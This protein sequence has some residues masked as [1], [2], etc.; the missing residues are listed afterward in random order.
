M[1]L[2]LGSEEGALG[3][4]RVTTEG[5]ESQLPPRFG[6]FWNLAKGKYHTSYSVRPAGLQRR[7]RT[8]A[9][10]VCILLRSAQFLNTC[11]KSLHHL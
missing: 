6:T 2:A 8:L 11:N 1:A 4:R 7:T 5:R 10:P 3:E 9:L